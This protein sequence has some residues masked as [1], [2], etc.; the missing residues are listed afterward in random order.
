MGSFVGRSSA[1][2]PDSRI[3]P[4]KTKPSPTRY[5]DQLFQAHTKT[6][7]F[8][9]PFYQRQQRARPVPKLI[10]AST[11]SMISERSPRIDTTENSTTIFNPLKSPNG[12]IQ[13]NVKAAQVEHPPQ[14]RHLTHPQSNTS[15]SCRR[16]TSITCSLQHRICSKPTNSP[17]SPATTEVRK[18]PT[19][20]AD[21][22][23]RPRPI[24]SEQLSTDADISTSID[25]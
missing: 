24:L 11:F 4:Q 21:A 14:K 12:S 22:L 13:G 16:K 23:F 7:S 9:S 8:R 19:R 5:A 20:Y 2:A 1:N 15:S 25:H 6:A 18:S 17:L 10:R 3:Q